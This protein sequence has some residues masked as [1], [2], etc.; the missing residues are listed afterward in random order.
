MNAP[1]AAGEHRLTLTEVVDA[2]FA[3]GKVPREEAEKF[4][5]ERR[6]YRG[7]THPLVVI[8]EQ[9][10]KSPQPPYR[11]LDLNALTEWLAQWSGLPYYHIDPLKVN[12]AAVTEVMSSAYA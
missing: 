3:D 12:L 11:L 7:Q 6:Y 10:W 9:R 4:R 1:A 8:A 5:R 2:L